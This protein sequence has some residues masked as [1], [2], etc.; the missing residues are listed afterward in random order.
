M[1][2]G[3]GWFGCHNPAEWQGYLINSSPLFASFYGMAVSLSPSRLRGESVVVVPFRTPESIL[4][5][6][7]G[8]RNFGAAATAM[9]V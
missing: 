3:W 6:E 5:P 8:R 1:G 4:K 7:S 9:A 2:T